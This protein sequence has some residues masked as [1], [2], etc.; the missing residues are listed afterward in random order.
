[1]TA[2]V[3]VMLCRRFDKTPESE[4]TDG[5]SNWVVIVFDAASAEPV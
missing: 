4:R 3:L 5:S 1:M 2:F